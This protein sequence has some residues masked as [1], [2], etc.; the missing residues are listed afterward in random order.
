MVIR[1][2]INE[3]SQ[4][5]E[6]AG[7]D[8]CL[9]E[10]NQI[11]R[12]VTGY[13]AVDLV[14]NHQADASDYEDKVFALTKERE[15]HKPLQYIL[16]TQEFMSLE[17]FTGE[18][19][20]IPRSD[21]ETLVEYVL[22]NT[23][24]EISLLDIGTGT[25]CIPLSIAHYNKKALVRGLDIS[26]NAL[27]LARK[28]AEKLNLTKRSVFEKLDILTE[29]PSGRYDVVTSNP[30]YIESDIVLTLQTEVRDYEPHLALDGGCDGLDFY[31]RIT[32]I[33]PQFLKPSGLLIFEIGY[34]QAEAVSA[35]MEK[36]FENIS[37]IKDLCKNDRVVC[38]YLKRHLI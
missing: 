16:G 17:F 25:G 8:N 4:R 3:A 11:V 18:N 37:I 32:D 38:G 1:E 14:L 13:S 21:T 36:D 19:V 29:I 22:E 33:A 7:C 10:A 35:L 6:K 31:R 30:P 24:G 2:L 27:S 12:H 5:L 34:N 23:Q 15:G 20:L 28:N 9:F 26:D